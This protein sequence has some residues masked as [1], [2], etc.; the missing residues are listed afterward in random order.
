[1]E[2]QFASANPSGRSDSSH[3]ASLAERSSGLVISKAC[4]G[5]RSARSHQFPRRRKEFFV[6]MD[7]LD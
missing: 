3:E 5:S 1:V 4:D 6:G 2:K 7:L